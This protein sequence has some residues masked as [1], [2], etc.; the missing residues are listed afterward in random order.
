LVEVCHVTAVLEEPSG[1]HLRH[2]D[3]P[4]AILD[5]ITTFWDNESLPTERHYHVDHILVTAAENTIFLEADTV[6]TMSVRVVFCSVQ[7]A[8]SWENSKLCS[9]M[10]L[11]PELQIPGEGK[12]QVRI[13]ND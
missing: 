3:Q 1:V 4:V 11:F 9:I 12:S 8:G 7:S 13:T 2:R 6:S 5:F 10:S